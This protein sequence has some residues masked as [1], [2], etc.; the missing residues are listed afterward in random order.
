M[1]QVPLSQGWGWGWGGWIIGREKP[2]I[3]NSPTLLGC[4]VGDAERE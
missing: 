4:E 1:F 3:Y 2:E